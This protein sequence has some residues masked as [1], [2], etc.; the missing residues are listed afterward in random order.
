MKKSK[1]KDPLTLMVFSPYLQWFHVLVSF[2]HLLVTV[3]SSFNFLIYF[4]ACHRGG[5][6]AIAATAWNALR[7]KLGFPGELRREDRRN[8]KTDGITGG[9]LQA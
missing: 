9:I 2:N 5:T 6:F 7:R 1:K 3:N 8:L 4:S